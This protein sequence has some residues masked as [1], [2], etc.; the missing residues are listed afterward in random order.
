LTFD[1][2][3]A[4][5][6]ERLIGILLNIL[7]FYLYIPQFFIFNWVLCYY[8]A[9]WCLNQVLINCFW[10]HLRVS[11]S[12]LVFYF[13]SIYFLL[14]KMLRG[15]EIDL[16]KD[17]YFWGNQNWFVSY[18]RL[19]SYQL[20]LNWELAIICEILFSLTSCLFMNSFSWALWF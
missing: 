20:I 1:L 9:Y 14:L 10:D 7:N 6:S 19:I 16:I 2:S 15:L 3:L 4:V 5:A 17:R 18:K 13:L 12:Q 11:P 8:I